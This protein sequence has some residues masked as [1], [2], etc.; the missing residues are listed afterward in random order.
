MVGTR[1]RF[2]HALVLAFLAIASSAPLSLADERAD[3]LKIALDLAT[4][5]QS[6]RSVIGENQP[7]IN[8]ASR[9]DKGLSG[10]V[11]LDKALE[12]FHKATGAALQDINSKS[13]HAR[14]LQAQMEAIKAVMR[15]NQP[16]IN[17]K[18]MGFKGFVP[19]VFARLVNEEFR[20]LMGRD[21]EVKVTASPELVRNRKAR[22]DTWEIAAIRDKFMS[23]DW[24]RGKLLSGLAKNRGR[25]A[26]RVLVPEYYG[27]GCLDCH[28][29]P[30]GVLDI[31]GYPKEGAK[32]GDLGG[33]IS[34][35]LYR[36]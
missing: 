3:D 2:S 12:K 28:G 19:A 16:T 14:L 6:A 34:V 23:Q 25:D 22:P 26:F 5:L 33:V 18:G 1:S 30:K 8:D 35:T 15:E 31:T 20:R 27:K 13:R 9:G 4:M 11:V 24:P 7:L 36:N 29:S 32:L 17:H 10:E 21:A